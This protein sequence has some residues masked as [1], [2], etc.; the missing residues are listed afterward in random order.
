M[1]DR[2]WVPLSDRIKSGTPHRVR[3]S[4]WKIA[5]LVCA[6]AFHMGNSS[7][8]REKLSTKTSRYSFW[9]VLRGIGPMMSTPSISFGA[10]CTNL[11]FS[12]RFT[13]FTFEY[14]KFDTYFNMSLYIC[15]HPRPKCNI[16]QPLV[17][18]VDSIEGGAKP[19]CWERT[20]DNGIGQSSVIVMYLCWK[21]VLITIKENLNYPKLSNGSVDEVA[22]CLLNIAY[23]TACI[24]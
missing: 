3:T 21:W 12:C 19:E 20:P 7:T 5:A 13:I 16:M 22:R 18:L 23:N 9:W 4:L 24:W 11:Y 15:S 10:W 17:S 2:N 14:L 6:L 8:Q 1:A